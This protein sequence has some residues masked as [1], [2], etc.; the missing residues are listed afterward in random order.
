[1]EVVD[2]GTRVVQGWVIILPD[3]LEM[4]EV[5]VGIMGHTALV[6]ALPHLLLMARMPHRHK[7]LMVEQEA[8]VMDYRPIPT[9]EV[10]HHRRPIHTLEMPTE[11]H[12]QHMEDTHHPRHLHYR[13][14]EMER[15]VLLHQTLILLL[16]GM[17]VVMVEAMEAED[18]VV[19]EVAGVDT[20]EA[21][22]GKYSL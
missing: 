22:G 17:V 13:G 8:M 20:V 1:V 2:L 5:E 19:M 10:D 12:Q 9:L 3:L 7:P 21:V 6:Q 18:T 16:Q 4:A 14:M 15:T 11:R